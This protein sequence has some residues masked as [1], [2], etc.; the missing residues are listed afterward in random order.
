MNPRYAGDISPNSLFSVCSI[1]VFNFCSEVKNTATDA[2]IREFVIEESMPKLN[3]R[4]LTSKWWF[5]LLLFLI[6][7]LV[8]PYTSK[9]LAYEQIGELMGTVVREALKPYDWL[10]PVFHLV[11]IV[12]VI[13]LWKFNQKI[14]RY[15][16]AYLAVNFV[17]MALAQNITFN[18]KFGFVVISN[19]LLH[20]L[21]IAILWVPA[22]FRH[23]NDFMPSALEKWRFWAVPLAIL[24]FWAPMDA[25]GQPNF[26]PTLL[27]TS[28][29]GLAFCF[30]APV[31]IFILTLY[32][33]NVYKPAY[34]FLCIVG[35]YIGM[36][37]LIGPLTITGYPVWV[38]FLHIP[39]FAISIY[40][41]ALKRMKPSITKQV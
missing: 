4:T 28:L 21:I 35:A 6:P 11:T 17:F 36:L 1:I 27:L 13:L 16:Y 9:S 30:T 25:L 24:A 34:S 18:E 32:Y 26:S 33:P 19:N 37:N 14:F 5:Y 7:L 41:L 20:I 39:L 38:A 40:G 31:L 23:E 3:L 2:F 12:F 22:I 10:A 15:F 29:Y 8:P